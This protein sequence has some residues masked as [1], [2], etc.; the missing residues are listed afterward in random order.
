MDTTLKWA[1]EN[2]NFKTVEDLLGSDI[3]LVIG[4]LSSAREEIL[5]VVSEILAGNLC[6]S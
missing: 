3:S 2:S 6:Y 1:R 5:K 4:V